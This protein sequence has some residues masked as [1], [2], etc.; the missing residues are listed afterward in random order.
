[1][2]VESE[3]F[4]AAW[5]WAVDQAQ[6]ERLDRAM[7][8]LLRFCWQSGHYRQAEAAYGAAA[9][10]A[11][12]AARAATDSSRKATCLQVQ[13]R[14]LAWQSNF[15][16]ALGKRGLA[17]RLQQQCLT[18]LEDPALAGRDTR[19]E[20]AILAYC[21]ALTLHGVDFERAKQQF[22]ESF[23]LFRDLDL[24]WGMAWA[25][26]GWGNTAAILGSH[27]EARQRLEEGLAISR[28]L[29][30][31]SAVS[32]SLGFLAYLARM[33]GRFEEA[34]TLARQAYDTS[35]GQGTQDRAG[36]E[37]LFLAAALEHLGRFSEAH[38]IQRE[39]LARLSEIGNRNRYTQAHSARVRIGMHRGRYEKARNQGETG[40]ALARAYGPRFCV[41]L[42]LLLLG[43]L[44]IVEGAFASALQHTQDSIAVYEEYGPTDDLSWGYAVLALAAHGLGDLGETRRHLLRALQIALDLG[45]VPPLL[46]ALPAAALL[47]A[48][49]GGNERA[50]E[51]YALASRYPLVANSRWFTDVAGAQIAAIA[52]ALPPA[53]LTRLQQR[54][55]TLDLQA[56]AT[57]LLTELQPRP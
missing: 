39:G 17:R 30:D 49:Q 24:Q 53:Q 57:Q 13:V 55:Q 26:S 27:Q 42:N 47:L 20:R 21:V 2:E 33:E 5:Y 41:G 38:A 44:D 37:H 22:E 15:Q 25:L 56:T 3:N 36:M 31:Q 19:L 54:A 40:L 32:F 10:A 51:L 34:A 4:R 16:R 18:I 12:D 43:C 14:A 8:G 6:V 50:V 29:G 9:S 52:A 46:W 35:L 28:A 7:R 48:S 23:A 45:V 1:M 11:A